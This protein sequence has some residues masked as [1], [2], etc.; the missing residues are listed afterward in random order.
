MWYQI[1]KEEEGEVTWLTLKEG[2]NSRHG[3]TE[4]DDFFWRS[5]KA[6]TGWFDAI[7]PKPIRETPQPSG[8]VE[9]VSIDCLFH[10]WSEGRCEDRCSSHEATN[11]VC[12]SRFGSV[13]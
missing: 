9:S 3:P 11:V 2:L 6:Q 10:W 1:L 5:Y 13:L 7:V 8:D 4:F 12:S